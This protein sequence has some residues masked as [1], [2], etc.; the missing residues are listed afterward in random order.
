MFSRADVWR[1]ARLAIDARP[2]A[3]GAP[4]RRRWSARPPASAWRRAGRQP[5]ALPRAQGVGTRTARRRAD[6]AG[7]DAHGR[8]RPRRRGAQLDERWERALPPD[9]GAWAWAAVGQAG[10]DQAAARSGRLL[11]ARRDAPPAKARRDDRL[12]RRHAGLEGACRAARRRRPGALAA[13]VQAIDAMSADEQRDAAWVYWK[14]RALQAL[15]QD[16]QDGESLRAPGARAAVGIAGAAEL[17]RRARRRGPRPA[18]LPAAAPGA[19]DRR[20]ARRRAA[21]IRAWR[22]RCS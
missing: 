19:A 12:A 6:D 18:A 2:A 14:A 17:L 20:R 16:S 11:P 7:A 13:V 3:R 10:G 1:K 8:E 15:A 4:G 21:A 22:A 5:G 9:L